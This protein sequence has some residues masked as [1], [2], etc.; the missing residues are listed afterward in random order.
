MVAIVPDKP[1]PPKRSIYPEAHTGPLSEDH[2]TYAKPKEWAG[3]HD[4]DVQKWVVVLVA[5]FTGTI[6]F[7]IVYLTG[8]GKP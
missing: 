4:K 7:L 8:F 3:K 1:S 6:F 2:A 5:L